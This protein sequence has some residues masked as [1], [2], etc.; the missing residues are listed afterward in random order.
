MPV[1]NPIPSPIPNK[2]M[3]LDRTRYSI[4]IEIDGKLITVA[5][6]SLL[7]QRYGDTDIVV[8]GGTLERWDDPLLGYATFEEKQRILQIL[9]KYFQK[10]NIFF[11]I[12][13]G[14]WY[15]ELKIPFLKKDIINYKEWFFFAKD[16]RLWNIKY[17]VFARHYG[18]E[19]LDD[20]TEEKTFSIYNLRLL[21]KWFLIEIN[22]MKRRNDF[23]GLFSRSFDIGIYLGEFIIKNHR[24]AY[25]DQKTDMHDVDYG[26]I[27]IRG[28][29]QFD[30]NVIGIAIPTAREMRERKFS[31]NRFVELYNDWR[32]ISEHLPPHATL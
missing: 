18:L 4:L 5:I 32:N 15:Q 29:L 28:F 30:L 2:E 26:E 16:I 13:G 20:L 21:G 24:G 11:E 23:I 17:Y 14:D 27:V 7:P 22:E 25:W 10:Q 9:E 12:D 19:T 6:E 3:I 31:E 8:F 1:K